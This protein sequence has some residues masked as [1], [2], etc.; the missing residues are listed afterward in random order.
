MGFLKDLIGDEGSVDGG[1][2]SGVDGE[3]K[4]HFE[5]LLFRASGAEGGADVAGEFG[6]QP[7]AGG[8]RRDDDQL[9]GLEVEPAKKRNSTG[10]FRQKGYREK[11]TLP[12]DEV[13]FL[14]AF[15]GFEAIFIRQIK[16]PVG[17]IHSPM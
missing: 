12:E 16:R 6:L 5:D 1:G 14:F 7:A 15:L 9:T 2:K 4:H 10:R 11:S 3:L 17:L 8:E 13:E